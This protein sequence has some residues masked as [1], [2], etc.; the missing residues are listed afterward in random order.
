MV[1]L[2]IVGDTITQIGIG[3]QITLWT[4]GDAVLQIE[5]PIE[6]APAGIVVPTGSQLHESALPILD[7][8]GTTIVSA[9]VD[10]PA[11]D[12]EGG[13]LTLS[14][15]NGTSITVKSGNYEAWNLS[16][17]RFREGTHSLVVMGPGGHVTTFGWGQTNTES[18]RSALVDVAT[19]TEGHDDDQQNV[20]VD[21]VDDPVVADSHAV[22][23]AT[24]QRAGAGGTRILGEKRNRAADASLIVG[25]NAP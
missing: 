16:R 10:E 3:Y 8:F 12:A 13:L 14:F 18:R 2:H 21:C 20:V 4:D 9:E 5:L 25:M 6:V 22:A 11:A 15:S 17:S 19:V 7:L 24:L 1:N 23:R